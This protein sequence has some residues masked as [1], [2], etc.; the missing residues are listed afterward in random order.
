M[1]KKISILVI[2]SMVVTLLLPLTTNAR[3]ILNRPRNFTLTRV[4]NGATTLTWKKVPH[5]TGYEIQFSNKKGFKD[6]T[7]IKIRGK[8]KIILA[9]KRVSTKKDTFFR[10]RAFYENS[11]SN[12]NSKWSMIARLITWNPSWKYANKSKIHTGSAVLYYCNNDKHKDKTIAVN[13]GHGTAGGPSIR[14]LS[15]PNGSGKVTGDGSAYSAAITSGTTVGNTSEASLTL[16]IA[17]K[18]KN[19]LLS[20]GY[21]VLMLRQTE[22]VQLDNIA[23]TVIANHRADAHLAIHFDSTESDKGAFFVGVPEST[24]YRNMKPV[25]SNWKKHIALGKSLLKGFRKNHI[26][27]YRTGRI[28]IDLTQTSYSTI[29]STDMEVG[30]RASNTSS[31]ALNKISNGLCRG[32]VEFYK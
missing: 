22:D 1:K 28:D 30:D 13:A 27:I 10:V 19:K 8:N 23:R 32:I 17:L 26:R 9:K 12:K 2:L 29:P 3:V 20:E 6:A 31:K 11:T 16:K 4:N 14:T 24:A 25:K 7:S 15:H 18:L 5:A 21:N